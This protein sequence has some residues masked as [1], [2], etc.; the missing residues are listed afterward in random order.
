M[1]NIRGFETVHGEPCAHLGFEKFGSVWHAVTVPHSSAGVAKEASGLIQ[2]V[3]ITLEAPVGSGKL[4]NRLEDSS[5]R[6]PNLGLCAYI[7]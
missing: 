6:D 3:E 2:K 5:V 4:V 7:L 1:G